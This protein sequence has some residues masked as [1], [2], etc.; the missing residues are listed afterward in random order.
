MGK[1]AKR[2]SVIV[3]DRKTN[4]NLERTP[5]PK[6]KKAAAQPTEPGA[7]DRLVADGTIRPITEE[8]QATAVPEEN[9]ESTATKPAPQA[10]C[11]FAFR[12]TPTER[13]EIHAAAGPAGASRFVK[14]VALA[15]T[16]ADG[17]AI[18]EL[19]DQV[20]SK[21]TPRPLPRGR[22]WPGREVPADGLSQG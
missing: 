7:F 17:K 19:I 12:L 8:P 10:L 20:I 22:A 16:R 9:P 14:A 2:G 3:L 21:Q 5:K 6:A 18:Q 13:D 15:V 1:K 4:P 11:T